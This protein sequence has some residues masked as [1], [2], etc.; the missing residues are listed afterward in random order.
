MLLKKISE[1]GGFGAITGKVDV[2][3]KMNHEGE[4]NRARYMPQ[5]AQLIATKSPNSDVFLF[6]YTK[7]PSVPG[8][9]RTCRPQ[10]RLRGHTK[11]GYGL[12]WNTNVPG[13][14]LS[15]SDDTT[16]CLWDIQGSTAEKNYLDAKTIFK[17][18]TS[19]VEDVAW[20]V[21]HEDVFGSVGDDHKLMIWDARSPGN[22]EPSH[23]VEAHGAEV[24]CLSF[25]PFSEYILATGSADKV[26]IFEQIFILIIFFRLLLY[27][28]FATFV[29]NFI[30]LNHIKMRFSKFSGLLITKPFLLHLELIV[31]C[32]FGI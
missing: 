12:S 28:I 4:V 13:H 2:E 30:P 9:D 17:G 16:V 6:D 3:I 18:H 31:V 1:F 11:E 27:G 19:V 20:H 5:N 8:T 23:T 15:A 24:N 14:L 25:N 7:H 26:I 29:L 10:L 32:I 21:L 22:K